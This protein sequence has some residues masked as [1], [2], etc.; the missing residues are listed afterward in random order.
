[1]WPEHLPALEAFLAIC[2]QWRQSAKG[3]FFGLDYTAVRAGFD[4]AGLE[5]TADLWSDVQLI[6]AGALKALNEADG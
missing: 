2:G 6:E 3:R 4:L 5:V 1:M